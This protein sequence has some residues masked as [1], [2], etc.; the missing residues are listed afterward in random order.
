M[1]TI[2]LI[3]TSTSLVKAT[4]VC[5]FCFVIFF[6]SPGLHAQTRNNPQME[7]LLDYASDV[8]GTSDVLVNGWKYF[9]E[10][11]NANGNPYFMDVEW[12]EGKVT[13]Q[14]QTFDKVHLLYN[15]VDDELIL[16]Q[17]LK[18]GSLVFVVLNKDLIE[19]F[20]MPGHQF[21]HAKT[22][23]TAPDQND[24]YEMVHDGD[25]QFLIRYDKSFVN[26]YTAQSPHGSFSEQRSVNYILN[27][28]KLTR[29]QNRKSLL[30]YF[31][32]YKKEIRTF[33]RKNGIKY[34]KAT[35]AQLQNLMQYCDQL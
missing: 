5:L 20:Q 1:K 24:F 29:L 16:R 11:Y 26:Q 3:A 2:N 15:I 21:V 12:I 32:P 8:Y 27:D 30:R 7:A 4:L 18:K 19:S 6:T 23:K 10:H 28:G 14:G 13:I 34:R 9:P 35:V 33:L 22:L 17:H 31:D 25:F